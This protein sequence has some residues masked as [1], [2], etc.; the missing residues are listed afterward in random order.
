MGRVDGSGAHWKAD[1][2]KNS[3]VPAD[4]T[5]ATAGAG[6]FLRGC[7]TLSV[8]T[9]AGDLTGEGPEEGMDAARAAIR[10]APDLQQHGHAGLSNVTGA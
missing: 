7:R 2:A 9:I 6:A 3:L 4:V 1:H 8:R 10:S 5:G